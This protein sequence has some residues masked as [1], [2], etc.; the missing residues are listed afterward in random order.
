MREHERMLV[1]LEE[2]RSQRL[3]QEEEEV[4]DQFESFRIQHPIRLS[5]LELSPEELLLPMGSEQEI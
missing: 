5:S 4:L 1:N 2:L 3:T